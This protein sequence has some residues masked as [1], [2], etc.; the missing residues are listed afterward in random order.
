MNRRVEIVIQKGTDPEALEKIKAQADG[1]KEFAPLEPQ[2][3]F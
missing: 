2:E 1:D 3:V